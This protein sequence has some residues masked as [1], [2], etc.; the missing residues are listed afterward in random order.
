MLVVGQK[1]ISEHVGAAP[2]HTHWNIAWCRMQVHFLVNFRRK[3]F[4]KVF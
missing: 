4:K 3:V 1:T 2:K